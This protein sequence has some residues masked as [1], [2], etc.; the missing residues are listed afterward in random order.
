MELMKNLRLT[1]DLQNLASN[2]Y[3]FFFLKQVV[4]ALENICFIMTR[5]FSS[6]LASREVLHI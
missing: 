5:S 6:L 2:T 4:D 3:F 1:E